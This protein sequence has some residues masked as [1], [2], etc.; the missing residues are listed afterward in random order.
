MSKKIILLL[1][2]S[3]FVLSLSLSC[4]K[5]PP[6]KEKPEKPAPPSEGVW[7]EPLSQQ[8]SPGQE[9]EVETKVKMPEK[10]I[11]GGEV[12]I[13]FDPAALKVLEVE[14]G[15]LLGSK[16]LVGVKE[17]DNEKGLIH[18]ALARKGETPVPTPPGTLL[19]LRFKVLDTAEEGKSKLTLEEV[20]LTDEKFESIPD[21]KVQGAIVQIK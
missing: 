20:K 8:A 17:K 2:A 16:P 18:Y 10:G 7:L 5:A 15:D 9:I 6:E 3:L 21:I 11:S 1:I 14:P 19:S 12:K 4:A 13:A